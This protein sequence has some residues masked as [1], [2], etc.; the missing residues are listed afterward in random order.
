MIRFLAGLEDFDR[1]SAH[2][3]LREK[4]QIP[5]DS[6]AKRV[7]SL[8]HAGQKQIIDDS[9]WHMSFGCPSFSKLRG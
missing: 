8:C 4:F 2:Y 7:C 9:E 3:S 1:A 6:P 5:E